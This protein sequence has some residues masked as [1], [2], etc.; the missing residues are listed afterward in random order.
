MTANEAYQSKII[1]FVTDNNVTLVDA[2]VTGADSS[3]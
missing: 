2:M 3:T 1:I